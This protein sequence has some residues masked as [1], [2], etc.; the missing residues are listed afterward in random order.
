MGPK[1]N[2]TGVLIR[3]GPKSNMIGVIIRRN[4]GQ[5]DTERRMSCEDV[6]KYWGN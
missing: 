4:F 1:S 3:M 2:M 5:R 6:S